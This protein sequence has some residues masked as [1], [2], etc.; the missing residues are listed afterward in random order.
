MHIAMVESNESCRLCIASIKALN[1]RSTA[2][3]GAPT[4]MLALWWCCW[5]MVCDG[6]VAAVAVSWPGFW[7]GVGEK[8]R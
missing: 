2:W 5:A 6:K 3:I 7:C 4:F 1:E 8:Q